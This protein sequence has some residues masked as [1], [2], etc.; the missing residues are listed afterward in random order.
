MTNYEQPVVPTDAVPTPSDPQDADQGGNE[1]D[2]TEEIPNE[3]DNVE[4]SEVQEEGKEEVLEL[5]VD[6]EGQNLDDKNDT[7]LLEDEEEE[8]EKYVEGDDEDE[9]E[10]EEGEEEG[11]ARKRQRRSTSSFTP[12]DF[13][14]ET[15]KPIE[16]PA[17]RG[18]KLGDIGPIRQ[19][20]S[21]RNASDP[22]LV[23]LHKFLLGGPGGCLG[24]GRTSKNLVKKHILEFSGYFPPLKEKE[25]KE[26]GD[27]GEELVEKGEETQEKKEEGVVKE[28]VAEVA[29]QVGTEETEG[30][31]EENKEEEKKEEEEEEEKEEMDDE[32]EEAEERMIAKAEKLSLPLLKSFCDILCLDRRP[33]QGKIPNKNMLIDRLLDFLAEPSPD[34]IDVEASTPKKRGRKPKN[35]QKEESSGMDVDEEE[36]I[37]PKRKRGRPRKQR[38]ESAEGE[39][40]VKVPKKRGRP[41]KQKEES[42]A[43]IAK[44]EEGEDESGEDEDEERTGVDGEK[45][46]EKDLRKFAR[47][48]AFL[49]IDEKATMEHAM[50][51]ATEKFGSKLDDGK[52][53]MLTTLLNKAMG[54]PTKK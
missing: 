19:N 33:V 26:G 9:D 12:A 2:S 17:G 15:H 28:E 38:D 21:K 25:I 46:L 45:I 48:Y 27:S 10:D 23:S 44:N 47:S 30:K 3:S 43:A 1:K 34:G 36:V 13:K 14:H 40:E 32:E 5:M 16:I 11:S 49:F 41:R 18:V 24:K 39:G 7:S 52:K 51:L 31:G 8:E 50:E 42:P 4:Q 6:D 35:Q 54:K 53:E 37:T 20:V 22:I 29:E